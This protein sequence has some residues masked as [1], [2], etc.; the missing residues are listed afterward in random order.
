MLCIFSLHSKVVVF[1]RFRDT[2]IIYVDLNISLTY[3]LDLEASTF[4]WE[5]NLS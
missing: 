2:E 4:A 5:R 1:V 3:T